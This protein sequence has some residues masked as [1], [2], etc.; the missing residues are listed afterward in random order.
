M[1]SLFYSERISGSVLS[2]RSAAQ[3]Q[4]LAA[5]KDNKT[6]VK[7]NRNPPACSSWFR[8]TVSRDVTEVCREELGIGL[9]WTAHSSGRDEETAAETER[10]HRVDSLHDAVPCSLI[11]CGLWQGAQRCT[12]SGCGGVGRSLPLGRYLLR[13]SDRTKPRPWE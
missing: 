12:F 13:T 6:P 3:P 5:L 4:R 8:H 11:K 9:Q 1:A 2:L 7:Y 10:D